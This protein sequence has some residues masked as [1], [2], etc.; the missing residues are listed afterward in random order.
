M[1]TQVSPKLSILY[2]E[3]LDFKSGVTE[4]TAF[5]I[6]EV[7]NFISLFQNKAYDF[8]FLGPFEPLNGGEDGTRGLLFNSEIIGITGRLAKSGDTGTTLIDCH[9][10]RNQVD[11]G[12]IFSSPISISNTAANGAHFGKDLVLNNNETPA[13][14]VLPT[15]STVILNQFDDL[16]IDVDSAAVGAEDL[17]ITIHYRLR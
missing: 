14:V 7:N 4:R 16:R 8:Q 13:G 9:L 1:G 15:I 17:T 12:S 2:I 5:K 6:G 10:V 11:Q 3:E